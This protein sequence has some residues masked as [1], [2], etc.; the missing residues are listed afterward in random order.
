MQYAY[1]AQ[2]SQHSVGIVEQLAV[3]GDCGGSQGGGDASGDGDGL[4]DEAFQQ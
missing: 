3:R 4:A 2:S 1:G